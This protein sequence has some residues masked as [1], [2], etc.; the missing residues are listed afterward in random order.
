[1]EHW[2]LS[3]LVEDVAINYHHQ[4]SDQGDSRSADWKEE[5]RK[6]E[7]DPEG[8]VDESNGDLAEG[9]ELVADCVGW[10]WWG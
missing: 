8:C 9:G 6:E 4:T 2:P 5:F 10:G 3:R 7:E 1:V